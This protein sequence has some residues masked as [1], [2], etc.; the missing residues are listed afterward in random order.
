MVPLSA[1]RGMGR[2]DPVVERSAFTTGQ[3]EVLGNF[4]TIV[5]G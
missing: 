1:L 4:A 3:A 5:N 2:L